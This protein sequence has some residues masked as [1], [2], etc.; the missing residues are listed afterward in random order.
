[1]AEETSFPLILVLD[2]AGS[3]EGDSEPCLKPLPTNV[4]SHELNVYRACAREF[5]ETGIVLSSRDGRAARRGTV[6]MAFLLVAIV[7]CSALAT[8]VTPLA[9]LSLGLTNDIDGLA[10]RLALQVT[11]RVVLQL[12]TLTQPAP[13]LC[14]ILHLDFRFGLLSS[15]LEGGLESPQDQAVFTCLYA[16]LGTVV[17]QGILNMYIGTEY[18]A[19]LTYQLEA[20]GSFTLYNRTSPFMLAAYPAGPVPPRGTFGILDYTG[21]RSPGPGRINAT[22]G[23]VDVVP[24]YEPRIRPW[25]I[26][27]KAGGRDYKGWTDPYLFF[28]GQTLGITAVRSLL[29]ASG[30]FVG[31]AGSDITLGGITTYLNSNVMR[32]SPNM[33]H[34]VMERSGLLIASNVPGTVLA[35]LVNGSYLRLS[36]VDPQQPPELREV[37]LMLQTSTGFAASTQGTI[38]TYGPWYVF[39][40]PFQDEYNMDWVYVMY[41]PTND[42][43]GQARS[44]TTISIGICMGVIV[45]TMLLSLAAA[46]GLSAR[47]RLL[48]VDMRRATS[49]ALDDIRTR[50]DGSRIREVQAIC[51]EFGKLVNALR[52]F[53][54]YLPQSQVDFLLSSN[55]EANPAAVPQQIT[56]MFLDLANF[57]TL[58]EVLSDTAVL[59]FYGD[60]MTLLTHNVLQAQ[61]TLDKYI[62]DAVMAFWNMPRRVDRHEQRAVDAALACRAALPSLHDKGWNVDFRIGINTG[63]CQVGNFGSQDRLNYT[64]IGDDVNVASRLEALCKTYHTPLLVSGTTHAGLEP[65]MFLTR[66]VDKVAVKGKDGVT[67]LY[68]VLGW[69]Q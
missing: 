24:G 40:T 68:Q 10:V 45:G 36:A 60:I 44:T 49:L 61:G 58:M 32:L 18:G 3:Q 59:Q 1:M 30:A 19:D 28:D 21:W 22:G 27:A 29:N 55:L 7:F 64:A 50:E 12:T 56:I 11:D 33:R 43:L 5:H 51:V 6:H 52:S 42:F 26:Q 41:A 2:G 38:H 46:W 15:H 23:P 53:Q 48:A 31:V 39:A 14:D 54:K 37:V 13:L 8:G 20:D 63:D 69:R 62:G 65:G 67:V 34:T 17:G 25:Y 66:L 35:R 47:L 4:R 16:N 9:L 57:T